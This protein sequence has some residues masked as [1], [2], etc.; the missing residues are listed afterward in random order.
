MP[1]EPIVIATLHENYDLATDSGPSSQ[2]GIDL[3]NTLTDPVFWILDMRYLKFDLAALVQGAAVLARNP[4]SIY[5]HPMIREVIMVSENAPAAVKLAAEGLNSE[6]YGYV[7]A[8]VM[9]S[10]DEA[11][12]YARAQIG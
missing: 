7:K 5:R 3:L 11:I 10:V 9:D 6:I 8:C 2:A 1:G 12:A 4:S